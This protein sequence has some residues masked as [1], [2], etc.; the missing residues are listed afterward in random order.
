MGSSDRA[1][2]IRK[3]WNRARK[4][5]GGRSRKTKLIVVS[6]QRR[7]DRAFEEA[8][9]IISHSSVIKQRGKEKQNERKRNKMRWTYVYR[10][11]A[12]GQWGEQRYSSNLVW[13]C[14]NERRFPER[15]PLHASNTNLGQKCVRLLPGIQ[16]NRNLTASKQRQRER[17]RKRDSSSS[18][19]SRL[20][21]SS[22]GARLKYHSLERWCFVVITVERNSYHEFEQTL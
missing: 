1:F 16:N 11:I 4:T 19:K 7:N 12:S 8:G 13:Q 17:K 3:G 20:T 2:V 21:G 5:A 15:W 10:V 18:W 14:R 9:E 22:H 6:A